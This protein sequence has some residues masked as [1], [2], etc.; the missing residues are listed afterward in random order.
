M[1]PPQ[2]RRDGVAN[3]FQRLFSIGTLRGETQTVAFLHAQRDNFHQTTAV[4]RFARAIKIRHGDLT[5][6][7]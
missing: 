2:T 1:R 5:R 3:R 4:G 6:I 7:V